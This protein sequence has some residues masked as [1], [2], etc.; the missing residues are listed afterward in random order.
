M[1]PQTQ[2]QET[3]SSARTAANRWRLQV[4]HKT[5][6]H[7]TGPVR[8]SYNEARLTP[9]SSNRQT[10]LRSRVEIEPAATPRLTSSR[11]TVVPCAL[12]TRSRLT[13]FR[14]ALIAPQY[15]PRRI[16]PDG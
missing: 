16:R 8:S 5:R 11:M 15:P 1:T 2:T 6:F 10:T 4:V 9:E 7:Y 12:C 3:T 14:G 13:R